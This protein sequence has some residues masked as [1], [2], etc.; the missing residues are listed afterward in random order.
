MPQPDSLMVEHRF[1][2][3]GIDRSRAFWDQRPREVIQGVWG[4]TTADA[5]NVRGYEAS[6]DRRRGGTRPGLQRYVEDRVPNEFFPD[7]PDWIVQELAL[8]V[9]T[10]EDED[11][12]QLSALGR[13]VTLVAVSQG[14]PYT[15]HPG[16]T[17][18]GTPTNNTGDTPPLIFTGAVLSAPN[19]EK[20]WFVDGTN[21]RLYDPRTDSVENWVAT[22]GELPADS[23][24][25]FPRLIC[26]WRGRTVTAGLLRAPQQ[27]F[28]SR[29]NDPTDYDYIVIEKGVAYDPA[30]AVAG[31][32]AP[33]GQVGDI[34]TSLCPYTD[35]TLIFFCDHSIYV[36]T[37]DPL[38]GG[39]IDLVTN[40]IG[41][42][43]GVCWAM[44]PQGNVWFVS[45]TMC[46]YVM[47]PGEEPV[48]VSQP[49]ERLLREVNTGDNVIRV[50]WDD[51]FQCLYV[52]IT[53]K[54]GPIAQ[55]HWCYEARTGAW[56]K[57]IF[58]NNKHNPVCC[59]VFDGN[60][61][62]DRT[63]L[64]GSW[65]GYVRSFNADATDD[66]GTPI[67]WQVLL[68]P[69]VTPN[70][71]EVMFHTFQSVLGEES[72]DANF[73]V[74][75]GRSAEAALSSTPQRPGT[76]TAGR[77]LLKPINR[78]AHALYLK[79]S[80]NEPFSHEQTRIEIS[81]RGPTKQRGH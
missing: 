48:L 21:Y 51:R 38:A 65:D 66:D 10:A 75:L 35:D 47:K 74:L 20:L 76:L 40:A 41:G 68:G 52:F 24:N 13:L 6:T 62:A 79:M 71:D 44:D 29:V 72:G 42:V 59:C 46:V 64:I 39:S 36:M 43:F 3:A 67:E 73:S 56:W 70:L 58:A 22:A 18:W 33:Q 80:G 57:M 7:D 23:E 27:W 8:I 54:D 19:V 1:P 2:V 14:Y 78:A 61:P 17:E 37:G 49:I 11:L 5:V 60:E 77:N 26:T 32:V 31:T 53:F 55:T 28:M 25:N 12:S 45:N 69:F 34:I 30:G 4:R 81:T 63:L 16:D 9:T 50:A 15:F